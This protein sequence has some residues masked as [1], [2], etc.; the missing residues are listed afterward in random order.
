VLKVFK[1]LLA[2]PS[3]ELAISCRLCYVGWK[4]VSLIGLNG[5]QPMCG[6][7]FVV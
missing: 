3:R 6:E 7:V 5:D 1:W 4:N 2:G